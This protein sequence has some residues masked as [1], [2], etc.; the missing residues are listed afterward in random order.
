[1]IVIFHPILFVSFPQEDVGPVAALERRQECVLQRL[2]EM[3]S[4]VSRLN[5]KYNITNTVAGGGS[6]GGGGSAASANSVSTTS[7]F[8]V[9]GSKKSTSIPSVVSGVT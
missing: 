6:A 5:Q 3:R 1:M 8:S 7:S 4:T 9:M 2:E